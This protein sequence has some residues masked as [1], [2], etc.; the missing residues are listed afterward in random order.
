MSQVW[1]QDYLK[2][3]AAQYILAKLIRKRNSAKTAREYEE[4]DP[5]VHMWTKEERRLKRILGH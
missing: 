5:L 4:I 3:L 2:L 1:T